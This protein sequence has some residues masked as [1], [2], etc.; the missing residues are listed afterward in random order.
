MVIEPLLTM[1][2]LPAKRLQLPPLD[3]E[4][5]LLLR[6]QIL[7]PERGVNPLQLQAGIEAEQD[8]SVLGY[9]PRG[10]WS[11]P[12]SGNE[13]KPP[14]AEISYTDLLTWFLTTPAGFKNSQ[15]LIYPYDQ[16]TYQIPNT[17]ATVS[18]TAPQAAQPT[19]NNG[20]ITSPQA[21]SGSFL[22]ALPNPIRLDGFGVNNSNRV[23]WVLFA[24]TP[25]APAK[26]STPVPVGG[27]FDIPTGYVG[28]IQLAI[29]PGNA[30]PTGTIDITEFN[31]V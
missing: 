15:L 5:S 12:G 1:Q 11:I 27:N 4:G 19:S 17:G 24:S 21:V 20:A 13:R 8:I 25:A 29:A 14:L 30:P 2:L 18:F 28:A 16:P 9:L 3:Y 26:P 31:A 10:Q 23:V 6:W 22:G 7:L